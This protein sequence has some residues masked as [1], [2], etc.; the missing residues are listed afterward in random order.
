MS[1]CP[2][3][4]EKE[5]TGCCGAYHS[6]ERPAPTAEALMRSRYCAF[7]KED[8][9]YLKKTLTPDQQRDFSEKET[10]RWAKESEWLGLEIIRTEE[11]GGEE[12]DKGVVEFVARFR[13]EDREQEHRETAR[14]EKK[15]G[16][17][18]YAGALNTPANRVQREGPKLGRNDPCPCGSGK[19]YKK[20]CGALGASPP[21]KPEAS[22]KAQG[23]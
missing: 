8:V 1:L 15:D 6:G 11:E 2:C 18:L 4:S 21:G 13:F 3:G 10:L 16:N 23:I 20:C 22:E 17:W 7:V 5:Y 12:D 14:F 9:A 19:K